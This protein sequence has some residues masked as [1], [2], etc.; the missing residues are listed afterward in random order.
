MH[1][2]VVDFK[3]VR[4][5]GALCNQLE[6]ILRCPEEICAWVIGRIATPILWH[7]RI[8][9]AGNHV[10]KHALIRLDIDENTAFF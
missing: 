3:D 1:L 6:V 5:K 8:L 4:G 9:A 7:A 10:M 2:F